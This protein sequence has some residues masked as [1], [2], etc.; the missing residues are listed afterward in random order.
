MYRGGTGVT[1]TIAVANTVGLAK[2]TAV[3]TAVVVVETAGAVNNPV[4]E[5]WPTEAFQVTAV[6]LVLLTVA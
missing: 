1:V 3:T 2:L 4:L 6:L 5:I